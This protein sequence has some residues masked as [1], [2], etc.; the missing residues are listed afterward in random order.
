MNRIDLNKHLQVWGEMVVWMRENFG[1]PQGWEDKAME[2]EQLKGSYRWAM[3]D[4][5]TRI[6]DPDS[7]AWPCFWIPDGPMYTMFLLKWK[8]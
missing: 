6:Y 7:M 4:H 8:Q 5:R 3:G 1:D 2:P